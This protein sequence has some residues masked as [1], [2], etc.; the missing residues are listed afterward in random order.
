M[1]QRIEL[2]QHKRIVECKLSDMI[3]VEIAISIIGLVAKQFF[4]TLNQRRIVR[5]QPLST[6]ICVVNRNAQRFKN[7][8]HGCFAAADAAGNAHAQ[9]GTLH[10][11]WC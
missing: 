4:D 2:F 8:A 11:R 10:I 1:H 7:L 5:H 9:W 6:I 3:A